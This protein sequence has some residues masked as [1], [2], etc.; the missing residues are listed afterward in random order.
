MKQKA[1]IKEWSPLHTRII[2]SRIGDGTL[3]FY[4]RVVWDNKHIDKMTK[5][6]D[7][8]NIKHWK[9]VIGDKY[10]TYKFVLPSFIFR[11]FS[12]RFN[13]E[14]PRI[15]E[16]KRYLLDS[17]NKL[18]RPNK[19]QAICSLIVDDGSFVNWRPVIF[20]DQDKAVVLKVKELWDSL[21]PE[22]SKMSYITTK[23]G[24][25][26]YHLFSNRDGVI[27]LFN[28]IQESKKKFGDI[29][30]LWHKQKDLEDR[31][32]KA[33]NKRAKTLYETKQKKKY[34][35]EKILDEFKRNKNLEFSEIKNLLNIHDD[36]IRNIIKELEKENKIFIIRAGNRSRY[37][38]EKED[39]SQE[40]RERIII[41]FLTKNKS[42]KTKDVCKLLN[43]KMSQSFKSL[44]RM[45]N[46]DL[47]KQEWQNYY[48]KGS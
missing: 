22:T 44:K 2:A 41:N 43:L 32:E 33:T 5:L 12:N 13:K 20:E 3:N 15:I 23:K 11:E 18:D 36:R 10:G 39:I 48:L 30:D 28:E 25:K 7:I 38:L 21:F 24:T 9:P 46:K 1:T 6:F 19:I 40:Y 34:W 35:K 42:I 47:L 45:V 27:E 14:Y 17:I 31:F 16:D 29:A 26:V 4:K 8:L 37:S